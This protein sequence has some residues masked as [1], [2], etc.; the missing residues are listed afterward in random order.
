MGCCRAGD[1]VAAGPSVARVRR[2]MAVDQA[3]GLLK[4]ASLG[5]N[6]RPR[7]ANVVEVFGFSADA[8][9]PLG[10]EA[11]VFHSEEEARKYVSQLC[12]HLSISRGK[13]ILVCLYLPFSYFWFLFMSACHLPISWYLSTWEFEPLTFVRLQMRTSREAFACEI[14]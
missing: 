9:P 10:E 1:W 4:E 11:F 6:L 2:L 13:A 14:E 8:L 12:L 7:A 3:Q 5:Q